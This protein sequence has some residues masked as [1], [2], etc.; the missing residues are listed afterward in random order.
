MLSSL[1][2]RP[3]LDGGQFQVVV[4]G[5]GINGV[6]IARECAR[7]GARTLLAERHDFASGTTS[8][9]TRIIHGGL[10]YL[11]HAEFG[12]VRESLKER[13]RLLAGSPHLV[14]PLRFLLALNG[15]GRHSSL[16]IRAG[17]WL[18]RRM[19][20]SPQISNG[21]RD[22]AQLERWLDHNSHWTLFDYEDAQCEFPERLVAEWAVEAAAMG[23]VLRNHTDVLAVEGQNRRVSAVRLRDS[24]TQTEY[25]VSCDWVINAAGPWVD[26]VCAATGVNTS[27]PLIGGVRGSHI[28][29]PPVAGMP[30]AAVYSE[31]AD[32][33][34]FFLIPWNHQ[35]LVGTTEVPQTR[36]PATASPSAAEIEYLLASARRIVPGIHLSRSDI[37]FTFSGVRPLPFSPGKRAAAITRRH[38]WHDHAV[39]GMGGMFSLIG[40]KL[41]TA[42]LVGRECARKLGF[43]VPEPIIA[44]LPPNANLQAARERYAHEVVQTCHIPQTSAL[45][46]VDW[47]GPRAALVAQMAAGAPEM[48][49][50]ICEH[51]DHIV[52]EA[53]YAARHEFAARLADIL[54]RRVPLALDSHWSAACT[55]IAA[56][57][58]GHALGWSAQRISAEQEQFAKE[59]TDL[60]GRALN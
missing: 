29:L 25:R 52:A 42:A 14:R 7:S 47:F 59:Q 9:S 21:S 15:N 26:S 32:G 46:I 38:I 36:D 4:I 57:R 10:R 19:S 55:R 22:R 12:L 45:G 13:D 41:T 30:N 20:P 60:L 51:A 43:I 44:V 28:V 23:A 37:S 17:L 11:E 49:L 35:L 56:A 54:L 40:G 16:A 58:I 2:S 33:R 8:R 53:V 34:P 39:D 6:A 1:P 24:L 48:Q 5:G 50:P 18:Y 31:A 27:T 3:P